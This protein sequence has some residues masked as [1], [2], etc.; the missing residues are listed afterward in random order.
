MVAD[1]IVGSSSDELKLF[2]PVHVYVAPT[3]V[4]DVRFNVCPSQTGELLPGVGAAGA[5]LTT[6][7]TVPKE[8]V[9][10]PTVIVTEYVP[11][12]AVVADGMFGSSREEPK[13]F[14]PVHVY[15]APTTVFDVRFNVCPAQIGLLLPAVGAV[16][17]GFTVTAIVDCGLAHPPTV[18]VN[19]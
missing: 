17:P 19:E 12:A 3:T 8:L 4:F 14:G 6:T 11:D 9:H 10:P 16:G 15:V 5:G 2:G 13:L 7:V 18:M 1:G